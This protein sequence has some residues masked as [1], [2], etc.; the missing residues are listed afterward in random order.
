M[1]RV[2]EKEAIKGMLREPSIPEILKHRRSD[3]EFLGFL[4]KPGWR[5]E[6]PYYRFR[7]PVHGSVENYPK[8][9]DEALL[10][11]P[12]SEESTY[13]AHLPASPRAK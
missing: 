13:L 6:L 7:C 10:C 11:P 8:G 12:A 5:G 4:M 2:E 1:S 3:A 9:Y